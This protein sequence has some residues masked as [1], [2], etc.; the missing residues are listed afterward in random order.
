MRTL[1]P[2]LLLLI[3]LASAPARAQRAPLTAEQAVS[4]RLVLGG[5]AVAPGGGKVAFR[6]LEPRLAG[7][8]PGP[9]RISLCLLDLEAG[10]ATPR[11]FLPAEVPFSGA[12]FSPDGRYL[13]VVQRL[14]GDPHGEVWGYPL[15]GGAPVRLTRT[16]H[17]V[18]RYAWSPGGEAIAFASTAPVPPERTAARRAGFAVEA[19]EEDLRAVQLWIYDL[20]GGKPRRLTAGGAVH[21]LAWHPGGGS[22]TVGRSPTPL[23]DD[24]YMNQQI[25]AVDVSTGEARPL[26]A[27]PGKLGG[28]A[29][30]GSGRR[31]AY[32]AGVDRRDPHAGMLYVLDTETGETASVG[33]EDFRGMFEALSWEGEVLRGVVS[34]GVSTR[35]FSWDGTGLRIDGD[36]G[37]ALSSLEAVA[38][39]RGFV[40]VA[41]TPAH[42]AELFRIENGKARRLTDHNPWLSSAALGRQTVE[43]I[44]ARDGLEIEGLLM[45]PV[46]YAEGER[47][48]L[49][50][51]VHGGPEAHFSNGWLTSYGNWGQVLAGRG[52][53]LWYPNYR[54]STG[55]G[56][57]FAKADHGDPMGG[58]FEDHLDAIAEFD[59]RGLIDPARVGIGGGSYGGYTAAWA[60]TRHSEHFAAAVS[61]VPFVDIRTKWYTSDIPYEFFHVHYEEVMPELQRDFLAARSPLTYAARCKTPLLLLGGLEDT[62]VHPSQP[63]MLYRAVKMTT[64]TPVRYI[65]YPGE[66][67]GNRRNTFR[68]D[69]LIRT[70]Q[71]FEHYLKPGASRTDA[72]PP[73]DLDYSAWEAT[74]VR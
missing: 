43:R 48:P 21:E 30:S 50:V 11:V 51:V 14:S 17:G 10:E 55:Y 57:A 69:Y 62:R 67:H 15:A 2:T 42:G 28:F 16:P 1:V 32:V 65:R 12:A 68:Y 27:N 63:H 4:T 45:W 39:G 34:L 60:A 19:F 29:W 64:D 70:M 31:L 71:W 49:V 18:G 59:R 47:Y 74:K 53:M 61:F 38:P 35:L 33:G 26:V 40:A 7:E 44:R 46:D 23:V 36:P 52:F 13:T 6:V 20:E 56:V 37:C 72:P 5:L 58:E 41:S 73:P 24:Q 9:D 8:D 25:F 3:P 54:A 22:V 66:G